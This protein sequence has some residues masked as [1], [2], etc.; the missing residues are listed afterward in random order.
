MSNGIAKLSF[1]AFF[2]RI[3]QDK[4]YI[5]R[6]HILQSKTESGY[7]GVPLSRKAKDKQKLYFYNNYEK[8]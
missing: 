1:L 8:V 2:C 7:L 5:L 3:K 6:K 4:I